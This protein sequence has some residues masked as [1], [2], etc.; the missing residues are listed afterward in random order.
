MFLTF[1]DIFCHFLLISHSKRKNVG[2]LGSNKG[3]AAFI[4]VKSGKHGPNLRKLAQ[5]GPDGHPSVARR[6]PVGHPSV[7][8]RSPV[9]HP[10]VT[11]R[12]PV[13]HPSVTFGHFDIYVQIGR[14]CSFWTRFMS[15]GIGFGKKMQK[16]SFFVK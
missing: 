2:I 9:G 7:T 15:S 13:G 16:L 5:H 4:M 8:R 10:S 3:S 12:S 6:S 11:R 14:F 1:F